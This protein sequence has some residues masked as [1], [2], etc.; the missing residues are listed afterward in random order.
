MKNNLHAAKAAVLALI[1]FSASTT[2]AQCPTLIWSD[3]FDGED[4]NTDYWSY[5]IGDGCNI[6]LCGWGNNELQ[7]YTNENTEVSDGTLKIYAKRETRGSRDYTS[8]RIRT[9]DK[10]DIRYGRIEARLKMPIGQGI[11]P[12]LWMLPTDEV[13]GFWPQSGEID[14]MEYL[15]HE[16]EVIHGTLHF[17]QPAPSNQST[18]ASFQLTEGDFHN[19]WHDYA[20]EWESDAIRWYI[21]G[22]LYSE[23]TP[24]DMNGQRWPFVQD[25]HFVI[26]MAV[27]GNWPGSPDGTTQFPQTYEI[28][29]LRV[30]DLADQPHLSGPQQ[31]AN[32]AS[33]T[34]YSIANLPDDAS[35]RWSV[36]SSATIIDGQGSSTI[37]VDWQSSGGTVNA[38]ISNECGESSYEVRVEVEAATASESVLENFDQ[39]ARITKTFSTGQ[40]SE[41]IENPGS[42]DIND[43]ALSGSYVRNSSEQYDVLVYDISEVSDASDFVSGEKRFVM[44]VYSTAPVG[45]EILLQLENK[46]SAQPNNYP[47]GRHSRYSVNTT[48]QNEWERLTFS[49]IDRPDQGLS[50]QAID[51]LILLFSPDSFDGSTYYFDNFEIY[52]EVS[53]S[54]VEIDYGVE[55]SPN[56]VSNILQINTDGSAD[57]E[58]LRISDRSGRMIRDY[59]EVNDSLYQIS[60]A[61]W[62]SGLYYIEIIMSDQQRLVKTILKK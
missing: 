35:V 51:Q 43:S 42:N 6:N 13:Y 27:G 7:Y 39:A 9:I 40:L 2:Y 5:Q 45:T 33:G 48:T 60:T 62:Q 30:Y 52:S 28:D 24:A 10:V 41:E 23:K 26:N 16:P 8:T 32:M 19:E 50:D 47:S 17:G 36:P 58:R 54:T 20:M 15:G 1:F 38:A 55:V 31:V 4:L 56:P 25:F 46:T 18:T 49:Y 12:A 59:S 34:K 44:D 57:I 22:Y 14:I 37:T 11:W 53:T 61:D 29:Y 21:D 3:E